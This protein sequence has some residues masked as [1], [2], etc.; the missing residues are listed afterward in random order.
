[1]KN[2]LGG[3]VFG[4]SGQKNQAENEDHLYTLGKIDYEIF[5][6]AKRACEVSAQVQQARAMNANRPGSQ[7]KSSYG[8]TSTRAATP[9]AFT[10]D[11]QVGQGEWLMQQKRNGQG[12]RGM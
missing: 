6:E 12:T 4:G 8:G 2:S 5:N 1:M 3:S 10:A 7:Q 11:G 9:G